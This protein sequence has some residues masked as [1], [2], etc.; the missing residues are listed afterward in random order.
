MVDK[1]E[2]KETDE[3]ECDYENNLNLVEIIKKKVKI[4]FFKNK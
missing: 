2:I 4:I 3:N 1:F